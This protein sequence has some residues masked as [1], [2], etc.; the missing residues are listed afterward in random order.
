MRNKTALLLKCFGLIIAFISFS[1]VAQVRV[2]AASSMTN[3]L[4][5]IAKEF[6]RDQ[7]IKVQLVFAGSS[8]LARQIDQGAPADL[9]I[10][11]NTKWADYLVEH[12]VVSDSD[13]EVLARN[14]LVVIG[15][16]DD[17][18]AD[19]TDGVA[20]IELHTWW[21]SKLNGDRL[22]MG[23]PS[24]VPAGIYAKQALENLG[25]WPYVSNSIAPTNNVRVALTL[26]ARQ[27]APLGIV[28]ATDANISD[29][30][31]VLGEFP[32]ESYD[33]IEYPLVKLNNDAETQS[34]M[35]FLLSSRST[36]IL[37]EHGFI[38][39]SR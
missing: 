29:S 17:D 14:Q 28:Y 31:M 5:D 26:V 27:E 16:R 12:K 9:Y 2:L 32:L 19:H 39:V 36:A 20:N 4:T 35:D 30:V 10:S 23:N 24:A 25:I 33:D 8:S 37:V 13:I 21:E 15:S 18:E 22:S 7:G 3:V 34:L 11:A 6:E 38:P 1:S